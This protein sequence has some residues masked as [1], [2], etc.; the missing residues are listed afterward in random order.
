MGPSSDPFA[1][2]GYFG[3]QQVR[4]PPTNIADTPA[5]AL[6]R[7]FT[8]PGAAFSDPELSWKFEVAPGGI[9]FLDSN[10]LGRAYRNDLFMGG[11]ATS[12]G[13]V[14][15]FRVELTGTAAPWTLT[16]SGLRT[17]WPTTSTSGS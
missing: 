7:L 10:A 6:S 13:A 17:E 5:E 4:W 11:A 16:T 3:M 12:S 8:L 14:T 15:C 2:N 9:G 1:P